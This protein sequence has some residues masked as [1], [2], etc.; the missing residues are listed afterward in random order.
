MSL[1]INADQEFC[2]GNFTLIDIKENNQINKSDL[3]AYTEL[4]RKNFKQNNV[5]FSSS[6]GSDSST[7][8]FNVRSSSYEKINAVLANLKKSRWYYQD[9]QAAGLTVVHPI[10]LLK[11]KDS[12][13]WK[14]PVSKRVYGPLA[15]YISLN[16]K[17]LPSTFYPLTESKILNAELTG[18]TSIQYSFKTGAS[19][20]YETIRWAYP[21]NYSDYSTASKQNTGL[22]SPEVSKRDSPHQRLLSLSKG[23]DQN[24]QPQL[25]PGRT[26]NGD[27]VVSAKTIELICM[28]I[29]AI[30]VL[31]TIVFLFLNYLKPRK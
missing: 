7:V 29:G 11:R 31:F 20:D 15:A 5:S 24:I 4:L 13:I 21:I 18:N 27:N 10:E 2:S 30:G 3:I 14:I 19:N 25:K 1:E 6:Y 8:Q 23:T 12:V 17:N 26:E 22:K 16:S 28:I 9:K